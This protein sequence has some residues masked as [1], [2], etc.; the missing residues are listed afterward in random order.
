MNNKHGLSRYIPNSIKRQVRQASGF[1]CV[2]CG[3]SIVE[4][5]HVDPEFVDAAEHEPQNITLLCPQCHSKVTTRM[6]S[7]QKIKSAMSNPRCKQNGFSSEF[8][9]LG[10]SHPTL[11]FG[12]MTLRS[13]Q[14]PIQVRGVPLFQVKA[15]EEP[16]APFRLSGHF[17]NS[18]GAP[19]LTIRDNEWFALSSN[20]DV[21]VSGGTIIV[22][23]APGHISLKLNADP[24]NG[25]IVDRMD[26]L[27]NGIRFVASQDVLSFG[28]SGGS[29]VSMKNC[30]SDNGVIGLALG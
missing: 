1:G 12:G 22:R 5:E 6:W 10:Q 3:A 4:Y 21:E 13:C 9:D 19:S 15:G 2:V 20:W 23:D 28:R 30:I 27:C 8:F 29:M 7:K 18:Q 24:P 14:I 25:I 16:G 17:F 26:M 11:A